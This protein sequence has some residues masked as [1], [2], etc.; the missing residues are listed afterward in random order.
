MLELAVGGFGDTT[1][2]KFDNLL[3]SATDSDKFPRQ[4]G[5]VFNFSKHSFGNYNRVKL[6]SC[7]SNLVLF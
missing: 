4:I 2:S 7:V 1:E 6:F 5:S 3:L